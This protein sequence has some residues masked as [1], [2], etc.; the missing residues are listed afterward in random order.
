MQKTSRR[1]DER[2]IQKHER[3]KKP[4]ILVELAT[5]NNHSLQRCD[6]AYLLLVDSQRIILFTPTEYR[7]VLLLL[8][9]LGETLPFE[10]FFPGS[11]DL[12]R[13]RA[14]LFKHMTHLREKVAW[15]GLD[16]VC[17]N[18]YGYTMHP[19]TVVYSRT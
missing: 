4:P 12:E 10:E 17:C 16:I 8:T 13:D 5:I 7:I 19:T 11:F 3:Y 18:A 9:H 15:L 14:I 1:A 6:E 2:P